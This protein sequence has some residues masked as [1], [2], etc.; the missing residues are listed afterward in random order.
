MSVCLAQA[1]PDLKGI[2]YFL[3]LLLAGCKRDSDCPTTQECHSRECR[4]PCPFAQCG[5][6][7]QCSVRSHRAKCTCLTGY[8]GNPY[9]RCRQYECLSN[10]EC[11]TTLA[12][13]REKCVD[14]CDCGKNA[15]CTPRNHQ[16]L[17]TCPPGFTGD[18]YDKRLGCRPCKAQISDQ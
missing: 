17:C 13:V 8:K 12:C 1:C 16:G 15:D 4:D 10:P 14:P 7:A 2:Q 6:N 9:E 5:Q 11:P 3:T 18:A